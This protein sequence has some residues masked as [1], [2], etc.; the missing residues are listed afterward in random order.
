M[1]RRIRYQKGSTLVESSVALAILGTVAV[2]FLG[3]LITT[4]RVNSITDEFGTAASLAQLQTESVKT[5]PYIYEAT[6]YAALPIPGG[7]DYVGYSANITA[8]PLHVPDDGIQKITVTI[9]H[10]GEMVYSI[11]SYKAD[12]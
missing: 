1:T 5:S 12:R 7:K 8:R 6:Q 4:S 9:V 10:T 3:G 2:M 11:E